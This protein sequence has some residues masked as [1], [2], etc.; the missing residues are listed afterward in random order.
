MFESSPEAGLS[1]LQMRN[2]EVRFALDLAHRQGVK[3]TF[4]GWSVHVLS[5]GQEVAS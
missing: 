2:S 1:L 4:Y 3:I 5:Y